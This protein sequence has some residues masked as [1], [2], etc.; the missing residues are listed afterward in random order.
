MRNS[1]SRETS[2]TPD[3]WTPENPLFGHCAVIAAI[4]QDFYGGWIKRALFPKKW[5]DKFGSRSHYW[6]E[7]IAFNS[8]LPENF[9]LSRDQFPKEF[10][11]NDFV[12]GKVGEMS[13]NKNWRDYVLSFP[14]TWNR[15][16]VLRERVA[17]VL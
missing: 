6:N 7:G 3:R 10:P 11:Y 9:D 13:K 14:A 2:D 17:G 12:G 5:A 15:Y 16:E 8:D 1:C 4:F